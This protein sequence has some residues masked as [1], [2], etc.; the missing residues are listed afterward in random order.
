MSPHL[1]FKIISLLVMVVILISILSQKKKSKKAEEQ[2]I[3]A[4]KTSFNN[5]KGEKRV[6]NMVKITDANYAWFIKEYPYAVIC[7]Y[8]TIN[9][10]SKIMLA[11]LSKMAEE[12]KDLI[13]MGLYDVYGIGNEIERAQ[14]NIM[15][16][17]T[18]LFF[19][20]GESI[21][22]HIGI[23]SEGQMKAYLE[24]MLAD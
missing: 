3:E 5:S 7:F 22:K 9:K 10:P 17:P 24:E 6:S 8:D 19:K 18:F 13:Y 2:T 12:Y 11:L 4:K 16:M 21:N 23:C 1:I 14:N 15:A 20:N